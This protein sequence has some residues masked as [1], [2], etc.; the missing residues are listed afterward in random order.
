MQRTLLGFLS[1][2]LIAVGCAPS[3]RTQVGSSG[4]F[5]EIRISGGVIQLGKPLPETVPAPPP[6]DTVVSLPARL[7]GGADAIRVHLAPDG[8]VRML[9]FDYSPRSDYEEMVAEYSATLGEPRKEP[10]RTG[11]RA[12]WEDAH[13]RFQLVH[14]PERSAGPVYS[15]LDDLTSIN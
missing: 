6:G 12:V 10:F 13:T 9:W 2:A 5:R 14:D 15:I 4:I 3:G 7:I 11:E 1:V 8:F